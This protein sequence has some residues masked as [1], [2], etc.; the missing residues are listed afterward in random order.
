MR[1]RCGTCVVL[2]FESLKKISSGGAVSDSLWRQF[3]KQCH[4]RWTLEQSGATVQN[5]ANSWTVEEKCPDLPG[6]TSADEPLK[7]IELQWDHEAFFKDT[8]KDF[9]ICVLMLHFLL[10]TKTATRQP[11]EDRCTF[12]ACPRRWCP[13]A[14]GT[15]PPPQ[16]MERARS[17]TVA[18]SCSRMDCNVSEILPST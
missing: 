2:E 16:R 10:S 12:G 18:F 17:C 8:S 4:L 1:N 15:S 5:F 13:A 9:T 14:R 6:G 7:C 3:S 11:S